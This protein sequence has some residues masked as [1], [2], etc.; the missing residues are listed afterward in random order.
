MNTTKA[1]QMTITALKK[2]LIVD[3]SFQTHQAFKMMLNRYKCETITALNGQKAME[4][5]ASS[6]EVNLL[7]V[8]LN[9]P[10]MSGVEFIRRVKEQKTYDH[11][12]IIAISSDGMRCDT[13]E[14]SAFAQANLR[15][16]FTS[17]ELHAMIETLFPQD[18]C[19]LCA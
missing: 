12:P 4:Q 9:M 16:P 3:D 17:S 13:T 14:V 19:A 5:L 6:P 1:Q 2:A 18:I 8:D 7:I 15:K 10:H 11:I